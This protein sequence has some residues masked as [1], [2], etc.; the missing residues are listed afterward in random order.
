MPRNIT[1]IHHRSP[2]PPFYLSPL[3]TFARFRPSSQ[4]ITDCALNT[5][6]TSCLSFGLDRAMALGT[7]GSR[8]GQ[9]P[10]DYH[11]RAR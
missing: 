1:L 4:T 10:A 3:G 8:L 9:V 11:F 7:A 2:C 6:N 5:G